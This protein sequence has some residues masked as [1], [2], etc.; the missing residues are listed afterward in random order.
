MLTPVNQPLV[1]RLG[2]RLVRGA[3]PAELQGF[4]DAEQAEAAAFLIATGLR[5]EP[6]RPAIAL[7]PM[8]SDDVRRRLRLAIVNDDMPFLVDSVAA[9]IGERGI[10]IDRI[11]HPVVP[12]RRDAD[13]TLQE[14]GTEGGQPESMIYLELE[15]VDSRDRRALEDEIAATLADVRWAVKDWPAMRA[16]LARDAELLATGEGA[17]LLRWFSAGHLTLL[18]HERWDAEGFGGSDE[19]AEKLG[20]ARNPHAEPILDG[21]ARAAAVAAFERGADAPLLLKS[22]LV[23]AVHRAVPLDLIVLP[24]REEG[25][26][27]GLSILAGLWTSAALAAPARQVP[28]LRERL[29]ALERK[30]GFDPRGH[31]G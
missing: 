27:T 30:F 2:D 26:I 29:T 3:L 28:V 18:G 12:V 9:G 15:R 4:G 17:E 22:N 24:L 10:A 25:R 5:R 7:E 1:E 21:K 14:V 23:S 11:V 31:T 8:P 13:G 19:P 6:G 20:I 16:V